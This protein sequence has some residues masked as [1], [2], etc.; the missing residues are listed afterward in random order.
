MST[1]EEHSDEFPRM[2]KLPDYDNYSVLEPTEIL[3]DLQKELNSTHHDWVKKFSLL[4]R[5]K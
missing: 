2:M 1:R 5:K 4:S 3:E